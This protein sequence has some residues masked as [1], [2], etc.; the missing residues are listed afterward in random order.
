M[1]LFRSLIFI[2]I[3]F[4]PAYGLA[5]MES[6]YSSMGKMA[7]TATFYSVTTTLTAA[8]VNALRATP[9]TVVAAQG[10]NTWIEMVSAVIT[11]DYATADFTVGGDEDLVIEWSDGTDATASIETAGFL[12]QT[13]DEIRFYPFVLTAGADVEAS[14]NKALQ[15]FNTGSGETADGG[16]SEVGVIVVYR[17]YS[18]GF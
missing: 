10:A 12:D 3:V 7:G 9:I 13:D 8:Q 18:T 6:P 16:T 4:I 15:I 17:V 1:R 2:L 11:Y 5:F 14:I